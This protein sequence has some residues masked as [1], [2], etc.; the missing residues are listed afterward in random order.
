[1]V[2]LRSGALVA[3]L[4]M[5][6]PDVDTTVTLHRYWIWRS[7]ILVPTLG[8]AHALATTSLEGSVSAHLKSGHAQ[9]G[10]HGGMG[11]EHTITF[12]ACEACEEWR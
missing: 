11:E 5:P 4:E 6:Y 8:S 9:G 12:V 1:M 3:A 2:I 7:A 10:C